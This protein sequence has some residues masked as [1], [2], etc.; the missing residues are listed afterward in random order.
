MELEDI[1]LLNVD[2]ITDDN[3]ILYLWA[4]APKP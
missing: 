3:C 4:T 2:L 1:K